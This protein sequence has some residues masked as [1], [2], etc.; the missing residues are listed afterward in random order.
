MFFPL[1]ARLKLK[2]M[3]ESHPFHAIFLEKYVITAAP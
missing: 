1:D 3:T 2:K